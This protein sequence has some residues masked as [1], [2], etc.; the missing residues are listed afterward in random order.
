MAATSLL[1]SCCMHMGMAPPKMAANYLSSQPFDHLKLRSFGGPESSEKLKLLHKG[2]ELL[3]RV[4]QV[5]RVPSFSVGQKFQLDDVIEAQQF[6]RDTLGAIFEVARNME[7]IER[8]Q[9]LKGYLMATLFYE[10]STRTR[11]SFE[12]AMKRLGGEVLTTEN[13]REFSSAA[14][15]ET[16]EDTIRTVEGYSD[17]IVMRHFESGAA[18]RAAV[19]AG[20]PVINAGDGP[21]EHPTQA[22]L[23]VYTIEREIG[24]LDGIK[25]GLVGDLA[26][27]RT[28]RSLAYLL[29]KYKDVKIYFVSPEVVKMKDD[30]KY[31]LT[32]KGV[33]WEE[34]G[35]LMEVASKCDV[36][37]QTRIQKERFGER[38]DLYE[39][40]RGKYIVNQDVLNV[41]Q[42]HAV[43]MHPL[44]RLDEITVDVDDDPRAAYFRQAK[45]GLYIRM[46]LLKVLLLGW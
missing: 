26:N 43:V 35:D 34:S 14:K 11:L 16:L 46:A 44:P 1:S 30:I 18:K 10:P 7:N 2:D 23:D 6:D 15:G 8:S 28:V 24:K 40:A 41:M 27:G 33:E 22:L 5:E 19:T 38:F 32:S 37:Y 17:I 3:C 42:K 29:A 25:V 9:I 13:A 31:Y 4:A 12:S 36:V 21:G 20:I 39:E 45:N